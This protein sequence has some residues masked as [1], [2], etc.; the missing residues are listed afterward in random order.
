MLARAS[1]C[2]RRTWLYKKEDPSCAGINENPH[3]EGHVHLMKGE[4]PGQHAEALAGVQK[5]AKRTEMW[6]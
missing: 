1:V 3:L 6:K 5:E 2:E 4:G